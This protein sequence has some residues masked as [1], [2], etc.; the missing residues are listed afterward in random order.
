VVSPP[1]IALGQTVTTSTPNYQSPTLGLGTFMA[2]QVTDAAGLGVNTQTILVTTD[3]GVVI[4]SPAFAVSIATACGANGQG[5]T[6]VAKSIT[7]TTAGT[8]LLTVGGAVTPG[9]AD[10]ILCG[11]DNPGKA[12]ITVQNI[13]TAMTNGTA[14]VTIAGRPA[15]ISAV[16]SGNAIVATVT[17]AGGNNVADGTP[18][19]FTMSASAGAVSVSCTTSTN[20]VASSVVALIAATG[21]V[22]VSSDWSE[23]VGT[24][25]SCG[26]AGTQQLAA[27]VA[28]PGGTSTAGGPAAPAA[29][30]AAG[31]GLLVGSGTVPATGSGLIVFGGGTTAQLVTA[32]KCP[33]ATSSFYA[34]NAGG[35]FVTFVPGTTIGAVNA[36]F[37][38][39]YPTGIPANTA[40]IGK[41]A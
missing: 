17:D 11:T 23:A 20:G 8:E 26:T 29:P 27:S 31:S 4:A 22:I 2:A 6:A 10:F 35:Q 1:V 34:T 32:S 30:A 24:Q 25:A 28:V 36:E 9:A 21:T 18:I 19:R 7:L 39:L 3:R 33:A 38:A 14:T 40:L 13:S 15:K 12:N 16:A 37:T 41:C 5:G